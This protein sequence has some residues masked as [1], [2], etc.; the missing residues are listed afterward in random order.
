MSLPSIH[1]MLAQLAAGQRQIIAGQ[2]LLI[3]ALT[4]ERRTIITMSGTID[5]ALT[6][7]TAA[8]QAD[9]DAEN[10]ALKLIQG[11]PALIA[12]AVAQAAGAGATPAQLAAFDVL[13]A[14]LTAKGSEL[15]AAVVA[16]TPATNPGPAPSP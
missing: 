6:T 5:A 13:S 10:A 9:T 8:V 16:G 7:L 1:D 2:E 4:L 3:A 12:A 14:T 15:A 11:I